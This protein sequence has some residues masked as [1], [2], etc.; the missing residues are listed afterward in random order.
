[1]S[2]QTDLR[3][4]ADADEIP[5]ASDSVGRFLN[6]ASGRLM[7]ALDRRAKSVGVTAAQW[8]V[9]IRIALEI[10][11]TAADLCRTLR[12]D[13]GSMTRMLDRLENQGLIRRERST[14]DRR[15]VRLALTEAGEAICPRLQQIGIGVL[16]HFLM[17]FTPAEVE[18]LTD[19]LKRFA[20]APPLTD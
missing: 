3:Q 13:T 9:L 2:H 12:Y 6:E 20:S 19:L 5:F 1:M 14:E 11:T 4:P 7:E 10:D 15:V 17:D 8:R 18:Q 16:D